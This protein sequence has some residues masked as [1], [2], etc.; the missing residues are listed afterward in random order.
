MEQKNS[1]RN[2]SFLFSTQERIQGHTLGRG[3]ERVLSLK[4]GEMEE[5]R[6]EI[7]KQNLLLGCSLARPLYSAVPVYGDIIDFSFYNYRGC[8]ANR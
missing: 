2:K 8:S 7:N 1:L 4:A 3:E 6:T 5:I